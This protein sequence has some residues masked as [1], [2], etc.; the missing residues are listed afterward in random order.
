[1][2]NLFA[3]HSK[4]IRDGLCIFAFQIGAQSTNDCG[5]IVTLF[6]SWQLR[7]KRF[8]KL[9]QSHE[10]PGKQSILN[11]TFLHQFPFPRLE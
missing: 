4:M 3:I 10:R 9:I 8:H 2:L 1:M 6:E 7:Y 11:D 5:R